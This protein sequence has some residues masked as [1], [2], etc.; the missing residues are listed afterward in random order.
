MTRARDK[1][2]VVECVTATEKPLSN[3]KGT[4]K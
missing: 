2:I 3:E 1:E 4:G